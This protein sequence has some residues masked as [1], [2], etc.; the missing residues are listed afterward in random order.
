MLP[1]G[2]SVVSTGTAETVPARSSR[3][4]N[5]R[6]AMKEDRFMPDVPAYPGWIMICSKSFYQRG[7]I[8]DFLLR[9][10]FFYIR[11]AGVLKIIGCR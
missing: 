5:A 6:Q 2:R 10:H 7:Q 4:R 3:K 9:R 8:T 11:V 1:P